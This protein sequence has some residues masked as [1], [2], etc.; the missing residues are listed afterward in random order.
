MIALTF[1]LNY[2]NMGVQDD[3]SER[4]CCRSCCL[5]LVVERKNVIFLSSLLSKQ[6]VDIVNKNEYV[7]LNFPSQ[8]V[9]ITREQ[10]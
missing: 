6:S 2:Q 4:Y 8:C 10:G 1:V 9:F 5:L 7:V 3:L